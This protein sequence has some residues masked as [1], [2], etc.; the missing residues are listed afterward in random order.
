M[1]PRDGVIFVTTGD[2]YIRL[3]L[4]A[5]ESLKALRRDLPVDFFADRDVESGVVDSTVRLEGPW[6]RSKIDE[7][8]ATWF[9]RTLYR[10]ADHTFAKARGEERTP[11]LG[12]R[13]AWHLRAYL[14]TASFRLRK[15]VWWQRFRARRG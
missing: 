6:L 3:A 15:W 12:H 13:G 1:L 7:M 10:D 4:R 9:E 8:L 11:G 14:R 2:S 5:A